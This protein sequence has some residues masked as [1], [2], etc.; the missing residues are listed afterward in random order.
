MKK[1]TLALIAVLALV[2]L[3]SAVN[4]MS[5]LSAAGTVTKDESVYPRSG[6]DRRGIH[7]V[8]YE[9]PAAGLAAGAHDIG[10][11]DLPKGTILLEDA[12]IEVQTAILPATSTNALAVGGIT[13]LATGVTLN[14]TGIDAAVSSPGI[15][16]ADDKL[17]LTVSGSTATAGVFTVYLPIVAGNAQ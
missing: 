13:V 9:V 15:T 14:A 3:A 17:A 10:T 4:L 12:V 7:V 11:V 8:H 16:T 6:V 2:S 5:E 1:V